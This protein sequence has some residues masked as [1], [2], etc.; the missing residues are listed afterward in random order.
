MSSAKVSSFILY[1]KNLPA[2]FDGF[3]IAHISDLHSVPANGVYEIIA[4][5]APDVTVITGDLVHDD[6]TDYDKVLDL[7]RKLSGISPVYAVTGNHDLWRFNH[8]H[9]IKTI[10]NHGVTF[11]RNEM[12]ELEKN[13]KKI[14]LFGMDDP[15]SKIPD[16]IEEKIKK[17]YRQ[18]P[19]Y[20]GFKILLFHRA[21]LFD[22]IK[23]LGFDIILSGHMHGG[24]I[25]LPWLGGVCGP[26]SAMLSKAGMLF[27]KYT[28]GIYNY[29]N[30]SMIVNRGI[31]NTLP[32]PR[33][34]NPPEV[35][36]ITLKIQ[37]AD[38]I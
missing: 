20:E 21:N 15:F 11:L 37:K 6:D 10:K 13:E 14:A 29:Q 33:F 38:T 7:V 26:T 24:Q 34:G 27:P 30:T 1:E 16:V 31:G 17:Y 36:I 9:V 12:I 32:V 2:E 5:S 3:K 23:N 22:S 4:D 35:G 19:D 28:A 25:R 18:L 8:K